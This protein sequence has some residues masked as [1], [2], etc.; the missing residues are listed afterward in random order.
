MRVLWCFLASVLQSCLVADNRTTEEE[1]CYNQRQRI[2]SAYIK[3][4]VDRAGRQVRSREVVPLDKAV[5]YTETWLI[6]EDGT[7]RRIDKT[8]AT[9]LSF[10]D[11]REFPATESAP[12]T[13]KMAFDG[14]HFYNQIASD[15]VSTGE[16]AVRIGDSDQ[17]E[18]IESHWVDVRRLGIDPTA[19]GHLYKNTELRWHPAAGRSE[20]TVTELGGDDKGRL[21]ETVYSLEDGATFTTVF[22]MERG[23][24]VVNATVSRA[25][26]SGRTATQSIEVDVQEYGDIWYPRTVRFR[27]VVGNE[28]WAEELWTVVE[29]SFNQSIDRRTFSLEGFDVPDEFTI[30]DLTEGKTKVMRDGVVF[31][32][33]AVGKQD[34]S[35]LSRFAWV[36]AF[37]LGVIFLLAGLYSR[38]KRQQK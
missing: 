23:C 12:V 25:L 6:W 17:L 27:Q 15:A 34:D 14:K 9:A 7:N 37:L 29:A 38:R 32:A 28:C 4:K 13:I 2:T 11:G 8:S 16:L 21:V 3:L 20:P 10:S 19:S 26:K 35:S 5:G 30:V 22:D 1:C 18:E 24:S 31:P 36:N 33:S